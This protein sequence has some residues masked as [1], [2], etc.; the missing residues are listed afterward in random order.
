MPLQ[1]YIIVEKGDKLPPDLRLTGFF[2]L[3]TAKSI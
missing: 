3:D 2:D 1:I